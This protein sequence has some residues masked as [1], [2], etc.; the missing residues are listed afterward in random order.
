M[1]RAGF[2]LPEVLV[3]MVILAIGVIP[4][5]IVQT[6]ARR[7]VQETDRYT[8][9][10]TVAQQQL[11]WAKGLGF[12]NAAPDSGQVGQVAWRLN[13]TDVAFGLQRLQVQVEFQQGA[14]PD[15]LRMGCLVSL[16]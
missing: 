11:E 6:Q 3:V 4:L 9:A 12:G 5:T 2:T 7:E 1:N 15:T 14:Q 10:V 13:V 16:R 8:Q